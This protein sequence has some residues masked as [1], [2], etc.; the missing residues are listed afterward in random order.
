M[1]RLK[2]FLDRLTHYVVTTFFE[3]RLSYLDLPVG[4]HVEEFLEYVTTSGRFLLHK[5]V[6]ECWN[7]FSGRMRDPAD[8]PNW[9]ASDR[10]SAGRSEP[11]KP[12]RD[13]SEVVAGS[14]PE[15]A[16]SAEQVESDEAAARASRRKAGILPILDLRG[17]SELD[18]ANEAGVDYH[19]VHSYLNGQTKSYRSTRKKMADSLGISVEDLPT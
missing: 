11:D 9:R 17:W 18:W 13:G 8:A 12:Q 1:R 5:I 2:T 10:H 6:E 7:H 16:S 19:T 14:K 3:Q 4:A 15:K